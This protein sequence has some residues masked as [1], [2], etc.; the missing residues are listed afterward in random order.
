MTEQRP[1]RIRPGRIVFPGDIRYGFNRLF[2]LEMNVEI[3]DDFTIEPTD[4]M[5]ISTGYPREEV[6]EFR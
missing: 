1:Q 3:R 5:V 4:K 2:D 6:E